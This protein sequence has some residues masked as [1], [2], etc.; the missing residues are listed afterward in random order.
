MF[1][2]P[3]KIPDILFKYPFKIPEICLTVPLRSP[4]QN[5]VQELTICP[6]KI[7][8]IEHGKVNEYE[9]G[10]QEFGEGDQE[11]DGLEAGFKVFEGGRLEVTCDTGFRNQ[12]DMCLSLIK[13]INYN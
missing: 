1:N 6:F 8:E 11:L 9:E 13:Y 4:I 12:T 7:P 2:S 5:K 3:F 10:G